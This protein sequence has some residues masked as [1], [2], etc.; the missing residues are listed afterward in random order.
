MLVLV[1][2]NRDYQEL[3]V[4]DIELAVAEIGNIIAVYSCAQKALL[5]VN[6]AGSC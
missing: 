4:E 6:Q 1:N 5:N 2:K 3:S